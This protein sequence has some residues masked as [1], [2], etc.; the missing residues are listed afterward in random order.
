MNVTVAEFFYVVCYIKR[1]ALE[2]PFEKDIYF[3][4][5]LE[6]VGCI[7]CSERSRLVEA[8]DIISNIIRPSDVIRDEASVDVKKIERYCDQALCMAV[9]NLIGEKKKCKWTCS[10][11]E[12]SLN[13]N[14]ESVACER[15]LTWVHLTCTKLNGFA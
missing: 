15:C 14:E 13:Q 11:C 10:L 9:L 12:R 2:K 1:I 6:T 4:M 3:G 7:Q 8:T 5:F